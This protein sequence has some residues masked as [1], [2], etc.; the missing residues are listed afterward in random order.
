MTSGNTPRNPTAR[1]AAN[2]ILFAAFIASGISLSLFLAGQRE[3]ALQVCGISTVILLILL[4][5]GAY[6]VARSG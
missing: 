2:T 4:F 1:R 6:I 3:L 5:L